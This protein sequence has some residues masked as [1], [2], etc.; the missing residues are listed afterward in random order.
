VHVDGKLLNAE[1]EFVASGPCEVNYDRNEVTMWPSFEVH[2]LQRERGELTLE[3]AN[4]RTLAI[5][6]RHL[7]FKL[8][9]QGQPAPQDQ[10]RISVYRL[11][12][13]GRDAVPAHLAAGYREPAQTTDDAPSGEGTEAGARRGDA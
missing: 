3:L 10:Q 8:R 2:A 11:R 6:N 12:I 9:P 1:G 7:T 13:I 4:G 5:S